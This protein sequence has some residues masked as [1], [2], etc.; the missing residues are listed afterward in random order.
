MQ[1][2]SPGPIDTQPATLTHV[3]ADTAV[4]EWYVPSYSYSLLPTR[5]VVTARF[6]LVH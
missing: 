6:C 1:S 2:K 5:G 3:P 4:G